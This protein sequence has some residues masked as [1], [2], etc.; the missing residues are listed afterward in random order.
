MHTKY[1]I[2]CVLNIDIYCACDYMKSN[3]QECHRRHLIELYDITES[4]CGNTLVNNQLEVLQGVG[5][6]TTTI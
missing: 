1:A 2:I 5:I 3:V 4:V 6:L